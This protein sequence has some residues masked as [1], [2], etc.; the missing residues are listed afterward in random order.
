MSK[1]TFTNHAVSEQ[2]L[3][4]AIQRLNLPYL[5]CGATTAVSQ[6]LR[7]GILEL[8]EGLT[9]ERLPLE[10]SEKE[11]SKILACLAFQFVSFVLHAPRARLRRLVCCFLSV[12]NH[13]SGAIPCHDHG[14]FV[15]FCGV[16]RRY[17]PE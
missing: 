10:I 15:A 1:N 5:T 11:S 9:V 12:A 8:R 14:M 13:C 7:A 3:V 4:Q 17:V 16:K 2:E 6:L